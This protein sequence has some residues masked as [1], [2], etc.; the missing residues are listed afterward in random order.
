MS[1]VRQI[2]LQAARGVFL[3]LLLGSQAVSAQE[4][5]AKYLK[6]G[7]D[8]FT[9]PD[10]ASPLWNGLPETAINLFP[11]NITTP[12]LMKGT[13]SGL[14]VKGAHNGRWIAIRLQWDDLTRDTHVETDLASDA[15]AVQFPV[16]DITKTSPFMGSKKYPVEIL[17]WKGIWQADA[18]TGF[19]KVTDLYPNTWVD[20]YRFGRKMATSVGNPISQTN[21]AMP[22]DELMAEGFGTLTHQ[23]RE[24]SSAWGLWEEGHWTVVLSHKMKTGDKHDPVFKSPGK[25][26]AAFAVW[27]GGQ[28]NVGSRKN[29]APWVTLNLEGK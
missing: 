8:F 18:E 25:T 21:R 22:V 14:R 5:T 11:Q 27:D 7:N 9:K 26:Q 15:C 3:I 12:S 29:Y 4:I 16:G 24:D 20:T 19:Q 17:H 2:L 10:P 1:D 28:G 6:Q 23:S 13:V